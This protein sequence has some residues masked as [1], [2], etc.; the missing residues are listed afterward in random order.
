MQELAEG[1]TAAELVCS[2]TSLHTAVADLQTAHRALADSCT[3]ATARSPVF[4]GA[5]YRRLLPPH[6]SNVVGSVTVHAPATTG[7]APRDHAD[8]LATTGAAP[9][10]HADTLATLGWNELRDKVCVQ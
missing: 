10:D 6:R 9:R 5:D 3:E 7:A 1:G 8:T 2:F 4:V